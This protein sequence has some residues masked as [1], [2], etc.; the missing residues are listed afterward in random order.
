MDGG[1]QAL[2]RVMVGGGG[3]PRH[4]EYEKVGQWPAKNTRK[5]GQAA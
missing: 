4:L 1:L 5:L 3:G 2:N